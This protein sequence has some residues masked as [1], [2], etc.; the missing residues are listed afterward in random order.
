MHLHLAERS[1]AMHLA[2]SPCAVR[3]LCERRAGHKQLSTTETLLYGQ[4]VCRKTP[5]ARL[6]CGGVPIWRT[7]SDNKLSARGLR[8]GVDARRNSI[9]L[10]RWSVLEVTDLAISPM[11]GILFFPHLR[12]YYNSA[13]VTGTRCDS[14]VCNAVEECSVA[15]TPPGP[16]SRSSYAPFAPRERRLL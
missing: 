9:V 16:S 15:M 1:A 7:I 6:E 11:L 10:W 13:T 3:A 8:I 14:G 4:A 12:S 2:S 5:R